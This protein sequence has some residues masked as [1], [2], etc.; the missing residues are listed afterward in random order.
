MTHVLPSRLVFLPLGGFVLFRGST[1]N[2]IGSCNFKVGLR[3]IVV[4]YSLKCPLR[5]SGLF[6]FLTHRYLPKT[7]GLESRYQLFVPL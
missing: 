4:L 5:D 1:E 6:L 3:R 2:K 7:L